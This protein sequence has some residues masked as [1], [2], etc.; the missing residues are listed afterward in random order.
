MVGLPR[1]RQ[2]AQDQASKDSGGGTGEGARAVT[3]ETLVTVRFRLDDLPIATI[4]DILSRRQAI[5]RLPA[6]EEPCRRHRRHRTARPQLL[7]EIDSPELEADVERERATFNKAK[8]KVVG[9]NRRSWMAAASLAAES[10]SIVSDRR[11]QVHF[12]FWEGTDWL[13]ETKNSPC[14][15][16]PIPR[17]DGAT[18]RLTAP[19]DNIVT[20][21]N[22][23]KNGLTCAP[24]VNSHLNSRGAQPPGMC[25]WSLTWFIFHVKSTT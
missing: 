1:P 17:W 18:R 23:Q 12:Q 22:D 6:T 7:A 11:H 9:D 3:V 25:P 5:P 2:S 16:F 20:M 21:V 8:V 10:H 15:S 24:M 14:N 19:S 13:R 4:Q